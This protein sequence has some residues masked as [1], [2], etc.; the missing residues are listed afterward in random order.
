[1]SRVML[2]LSDDGPTGAATQARLALAALP[3][4]E[5]ET[6]TATV[7]HAG[8][9][10]GISRLRDRIR[11]FRPDVLHAVG[12]GAA[13]VAV[14]LK[15]PRIGLKPYPRLIL[16]GCDAA[17]SWLARRALARADAVL[18]YSPG[19]ADRYRRFVPAERIR[20]I[21][22]GVPVPGMRPPGNGSNGE[23]VI[24]AVGNFDRWSGLKTAIWA[25]DV[26][27][28]VSPDLRLLLIGDGPGRE[29]VERFGRELANDDHRVRYTGPRADVGE[30]LAA[31]DVVWIT[32]ERGGVTVSLEAMAA[33][34]PV[35]AMRTT[36][37][38][39]VIADGE[40]GVLVP[41]GDRAAMAAATAEL[42]RHPDD[43]RRLAASA[44][45][46][47]GERFPVNPLAAATA[48]VY[49]IPT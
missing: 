7:R 3:A 18:A 21:P 25:F 17:D 13:G 33:G 4:V 8:Y 6:A 29:S 41:A 32:H 30:W 23:I 5:S 26:L 43:R 48:A 45:R 12:A 20:P 42:L 27:K 19:E 40:S 2:L 15:L 44:R 28:Y 38:E 22:P 36:D 39:S 11:A 31:A 9:W 14:L 35:V 24:A 1:M 46:A 10:N 37:T 49:D 16:S 34:T 47:V